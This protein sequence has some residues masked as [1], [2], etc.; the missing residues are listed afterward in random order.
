MRRTTT[1]E[2]A[3]QPLV[4]S[5]IP[6]TKIL[7]LLRGEESIMALPTIEAGAKVQE[8]I[9]LAFE[10]D[11]TAILSADLFYD[12]LQ[13]IFAAFQETNPA[14]FETARAL[15]LADALADFVKTLLQNFCNRLLFSLNTG[16]A[17][18]SGNGAT[19]SSLI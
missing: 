19:D 13:N 16:T 6:V 3:G 7:R 15:G 2:I 14:F 18:T 5:E 9:P 4:I 17:P 12:D 8:L 11:F 10:G 1:I